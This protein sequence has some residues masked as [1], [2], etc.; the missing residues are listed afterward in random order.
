MQVGPRTIA[1]AAKL[2]KECGMSYGRIGAFL[3]A[4][5]GMKVAASTLNRALA[6]LARVVK[7]LYKGIGRRI[8]AEPVLSPDE[9]GWRIGGNKAWLHAAATRDWSFYLIGRV[10]D[11]AEKLIG[12]QYT[13]TIVRDGWA[14]YRMF[15]KGSA[16]TCL[17]HIL[18]RVE[19]LLAICPTYP[20][21]GWLTELKGTLQRAIRI[22]DRRDAVEL[23]AHGLCTSTGQIEA[24]LDPLLNSVERN[25]SVRRPANHL[26]RER[27]ALTT[28]LY[29]DAVPATNFLAE[30][31]LRP[32]VVNRKMSGGNNTFNGSRTQAVLMTVLHTAKK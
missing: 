30:Q 18:R 22:R 7:P 11:E 28:F 1:L 3:E 5:F 24:T 31:A 9:T 12:R 21:S 8:R 27:D 6:R 19:A 4:A 16:Q 20:A 29:K 2:N 17:A 14:P 25:T 32:A 15:D 10:R 13:G 23:S 26:L